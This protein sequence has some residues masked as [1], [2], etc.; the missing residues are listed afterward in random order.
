MAIHTI[1]HSYDLWGYQYQESRF[2]HATG[3]NYDVY[4]PDDLDSFDSEPL[5]YLGG[6]VSAWHEDV[7]LEI[8][9]GFD[10]D[11]ERDDFLAYTEE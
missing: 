1:G 8:F 4:L 2:D 11:S 5:A 7:G 9:Y 10:T 6:I 3:M